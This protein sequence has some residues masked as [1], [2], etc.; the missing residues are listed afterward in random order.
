MS[1]DHLTNKKTLSL[2]KAYE[3]LH[4]IPE[5]DCVTDIN[6]EKFA[7][8]YAD[9][10]SVIFRNSDEFQ[11]N[12]R[13]ED[14]QEVVDFMRKCLL[15]KTLNEGDMVVCVPFHP[16]NDDGST[17][18]TL[19]K[20]KWIDSNGMC[21]VELMGEER[22]IPISHVLARFNADAH[23]VGAFHM[24]STELMFLDNEDEAMPILLAAQKQRDGIT[25]SLSVMTEAFAA[26][27]LNPDDGRP[28]AKEQKS[29]NGKTKGKQKLTERL[30]KGKR[31]AAE[32]DGKNTPP[33]TKKKGERE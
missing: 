27:G 9:A 8:R 25:H 6:D 17:Y 16:F 1:N 20:I 31:K 2:V 29:K 13:F 22:W 5:K 23:P 32:Q 21:G 3:K 15:Y 10:L 11:S 26:H 19:E 7:L 4:K 24:P 12:N 33:N 30:E 28:L 14:G 18:Y